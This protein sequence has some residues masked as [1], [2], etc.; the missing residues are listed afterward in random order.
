MTINGVWRQRDPLVDQGIADQTATLDIAFSF[1]VPGD[2]FDEVDGDPLILGASGLP[3][4]LVF[5]PVTRP[6]Q[7]DAIA[8]RPGHHDDY[9]NRRRSRRRHAR[10]DDV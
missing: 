7:R 1:M 2:A 3:A 4:W 6:V 5:T 10:I 8:Q 9:G